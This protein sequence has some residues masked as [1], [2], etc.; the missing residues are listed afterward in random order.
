M[1][2]R[3]MLASTILLSSCAMVRTT[4]LGTTL[5]LKPQIQAGAYTTTTTVNPYTQASINHL[6]LKLYTFDG[7]TEHDQGIQ[8]SIP[9][10]QLTNVISFSNLRANTTYRIKALAYASADESTLISTTDANSDTDVTLT[11][12]ERP[13]LANLKV[14]LINIDFNG[15]GTGSL[16][17]TNGGY[18]DAGAE[19]L[20]FINQGIVTT[21]AGGAGNTT[22]GYADGIGTAAKFNNPLCLTIDAA[23]NLYVADWLNNLIRKISS[24]GVVSTYAGGG[25]ATAAGYLDGIGTSALFTG[26]IGIVAD[27]SGNLFVIEK[28]NNLIRKIASN[29]TVSTFAGGGGTTNAG[30]AD[31]NGTAAKFNQPYD[32]ALDTSGNLYVADTFNNLIRKVSNTGVVST[33]AGGAGGTIAGNANGVGT[34][35]TFNGPRGLAV[36]SAGNVYVADKYNNL[37]RKITS[38]GAVSTLAGGAGGTIAGSA[39]GVGTAA[40]FDNPYD[41]EVDGLGNV[42]VADT[43]NNLVRKIAPTGVVSTLAGGAGGTASGHADGTGTAA[44]LNNPYGLTIDRAGNLYVGDWLNNLIRVIR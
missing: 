23:G 5:V 2:K 42:F 31:G 40:S 10:A 24:N 34:A 12:D 37:I 4:S 30:Y 7:T 43:Y 21:L 39:N 33:F 19:A 27:A 17:I 35:A 14:K 26:P 22:A 13:T 25:G 3:W 18:I 6:I 20:Q 29:K 41:V 32:I 16:Q 28:S 38:T 44:T 36:D 15:Q 9:N 1:R 11:N 8:K